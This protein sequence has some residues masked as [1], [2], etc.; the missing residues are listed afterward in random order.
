M[1]ILAFCVQ[2]VGHGTASGK[3]QLLS[4]LGYKASDAEVEGP[5]L[6]GRPK[7]LDL[8]EHKNPAVRSKAVQMRAELEKGICNRLT[9]CKLVWSM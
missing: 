8:L 6:T 1:Q 9:D 7:L 3:L 2:L 4:S 5:G